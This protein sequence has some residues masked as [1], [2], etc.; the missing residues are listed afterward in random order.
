MKRNFSHLL[1]FAIVLL[2]LITFTANAQEGSHPNDGIPSNEIPDISFKPE[3]QEERPLLYE[4]ATSVEKT[5]NSKEQLMASPKSGKSKS[6]DGSKNPAAK[7]EDDA[8]SF[9]FLYY[10]IQK[11][12]IS[13]IVEQ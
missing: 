7:P 8:L 13:D 3:L 1:G 9:N 6:T 11:F 5:A 12:K 4:P 10:I 2:A